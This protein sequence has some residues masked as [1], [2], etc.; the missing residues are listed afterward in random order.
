LDRYKNWALAG[1]GRTLDLVILNLAGIMDSVVRMEN[2]ETGFGFEKLFVYQ[3]R[4]RFIG[5]TAIH[6]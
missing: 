6:K 4:C 5:L 2:R 3:D 1:V